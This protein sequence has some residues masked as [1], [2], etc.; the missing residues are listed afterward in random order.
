[1]NVLEMNDVVVDVG[2]GGGGGGPKGGPYPGGVG[3]P[4]NGGN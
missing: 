1:M 2:F 3:V 4:K